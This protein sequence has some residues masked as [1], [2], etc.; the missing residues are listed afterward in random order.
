MYFMYVLPHIYV[1]LKVM[2]IFYQHL[3]IRD[4][5]TFHRIISSCS[6]TKAKAKVPGWKPDTKLVFNTTLL[7]QQ[8]TTTFPGDK[9]IKT[10]DEHNLSAIGKWQMANGKPNT[11]L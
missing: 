7:A 8:P 10:L 11:E 6:C 4:F 9:G 3:L 2:G 5:I 1:Q